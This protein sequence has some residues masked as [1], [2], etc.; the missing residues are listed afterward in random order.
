MFWVRKPSL[1]CTSAIY[2]HRISHTTTASVIVFH[3]APFFPYGQQFEHVWTTEGWYLAAV[4]CPTPAAAT[5]W[6]YC[7]YLWPVAVAFQLIVRPG[8]ELTNPSQFYFRHHAATFCQ[9]YLTKTLSLNTWI[10]AKSWFIAQLYF[11]SCVFYLDDWISEAERRARYAPAL[12]GKKRVRM[13]TIHLLCKVKLKGCLKQWN[14]GTCCE[15]PTLTAHEQGEVTKEAGN[16]GF[17]Q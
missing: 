6:Q 15:N 16:S 9:L 4:N 11:W 3:W 5:G 10:M 17:S 13:Q 1:W 8:V 14:P 2:G 7:C 12:R